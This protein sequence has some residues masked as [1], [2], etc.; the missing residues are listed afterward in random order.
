MTSQKRDQDIQLL[1][2]S[3]NS[4][5]SVHRPF[6]L[7]CVAVACVAVIVASVGLHATLL[8]N[9]ASGQ[10]PPGPAWAMTVG[11][12]LG[13]VAWEYLLPVPVASFFTATTLVMSNPRISQTSKTA[14]MTCMFLGSLVWFAISSYLAREL[15]SC[16]VV[17]CAGAD[18]NEPGI[19]DAHGLGGFQGLISLFASLSVMVSCIVVLTRLGRGTSPVNAEPRTQAQQTRAK[20]ARRLISASAL[21]V[22]ILPGC[23]LLTAILPNTFQ[24]FHVRDGSPQYRLPNV[25]ATDDADTAE[26]V[27]AWMTTLAW[28]WSDDLVLKF[29]PDTLLFYGCLELIALMALVAAWVPSFSRVLSKRVWGNTSIGEYALVFMFGLL[30]LLWTIYWGSHHLYDAGKNHFNSSISDVVARTFGMEAV[31]FMSLTLFPASRNSLWLEA[32]GIDFQRSLW[33]HRWLGALSMLMIVCHILAF[34]V[35]FAEL[36]IFSDALGYNQHYPLNDGVKAIGDDFTIALMEFIAYPAVV[37]LGVLPFMRRRSYEAFKYAHYMFM[38]LIP[39]LLLHAHSG[40]FFLLGGI[41]FWLVDAS[42]RAVRAA[43]PHKL[44]A[45][46][47]HGAEN[48]VTELQFELAF[49]EPGMYCFINVPQVSPFQWHPFSISTSPFD[50]V[51]QMN[52]KNMGSGTFT[53]D[54]YKLAKAGTQNGDLPITLNVDGPYGP[55][56]ELEDHG[57]LLLLAGGIGITAMHSYFRHLMHLARLGQVPSSLQRVHLVWTSRSSDMFKMFADSLSEILA[58]EV[59]SLQFSVT[60]Y[61][62]GKSEEGVSNLQ[63]P[64]VQGRPSFETLYGD[65]QPTNGKLLVKLCAPEAMNASALAAAKSCEWVTF[66]S[67]LFVM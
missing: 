19:G 36:D 37:L 64:V 44:I 40:W 39:A 14:W 3:P 45:V 33:A 63:L 53:G 62:T 30:T 24:K 47:A 26:K 54:L 66:E 15:L 31:L 49:D 1:T 6:L 43:T 51:G 17:F 61:T 58:T 29:Y 25:M 35:R 32:L 21:A 65:M 11:Q 5:F 42:I 59:S 7:A 2:E 9:F 56:L 8:S 4:A 57:G 38:V 16:G 67:E 55:T 34:W 50:G 23:L 52:I 46:T 18:S 27:S 10:G 13:L 20:L 41:A 28:S 22:L 12:I 48:G 60:L